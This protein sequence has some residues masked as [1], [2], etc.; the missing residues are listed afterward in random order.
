MRYPPRMRCFVLLC[1]LVSLV[2]TEGCSSTSEPANDAS[3]GADANGADANGGDANGG[4]A[5]MSTSDASA[6]GAPA[7]DAQSA[8]DASPLTDANVPDGGPCVPA[9]TC[10]P[11]DPASC[12]T[13]A[14]RPSATGTMCQAVSSTPAGFEMPCL[15]P[16][17]C[18]PGLFC[19][20]FSV[21]EGSRCHRMCPTRSVGACDTGYVCTG[22]FGDVCVNVCRALPPAC[23]IYT[24]DC[25]NATD[26]C[27]LVR[28]PE[29]SAPYT[30]CRPA[31]TQ[32]EGMPCGG[33]AGSCGHSLICAASAGVASCRHVCDST[34]TP[35]T[36]VAPATCTG[37]ATTWGV[38]Y[39]QAP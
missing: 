37:L 36:C 20:T 11:F 9:G 23:N 25:A 1:V 15:H 22:T 10:N 2:L 39:C 30:G 33:T 28:N 13:M 24:Q 35:D 19:L 17:D 34:A 6:D 29:T 5:A 14:C 16:N 3:H 31:G 32:T 7:G 27:T 18:E 8:V 4:D 38:H 26:T 12:G 21:A